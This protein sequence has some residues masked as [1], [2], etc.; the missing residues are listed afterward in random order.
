MIGAT[1]RPD[2]IDPAYLRYKRFS[3]I[4]HVTPPDFDAKRAII[5]GKLKGIDLDGISLE[6]V[7]N[8]TKEYTNEVDDK[9][10][11]RTVA[12]YSAADIC[13]IIEE[14]CRYALEEIEEKG[15]DKPIPLRLDMFERA[16]E[17]IP[18]SI[19]AEL[20]EDYENFRNTH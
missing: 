1:N 14:S 16:F 7:V 19:S 5:E 8:M 6:E 15:G 17:K 9:G 18:P 4:I 20:L 3:H 13:G 2:V 11:V 10:E 12:Y